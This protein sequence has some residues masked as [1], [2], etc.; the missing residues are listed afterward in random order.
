M[1]HTELTGNKK[2]V[3]QLVQISF[4]RL[5]KCSW[6]SLVLFMSKKDGSL[7]FCVDYRALNRMYIF[8]I[9]YV[10]PTL[11]VAR[12]RF[13]CYYQLHAVKYYIY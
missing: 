3:E 1:S 9:V 7:R 2:Q 8:K 11:V 13:S 5:S 12:L 6:A 4:V 10:L